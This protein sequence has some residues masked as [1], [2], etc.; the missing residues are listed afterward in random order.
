[1]YNILVVSIKYPYFFDDIDI[2]EK[3]RTLGALSHKKIFWKDNCTKVF[4]LHK[5][6]LYISTEIHLL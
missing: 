2:F 5:E 1:M 3:N 6:V 4:F